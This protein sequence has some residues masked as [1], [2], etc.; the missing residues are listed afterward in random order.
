[1]VMEKIS[2]L[3]DGELDERDAQGQLK[4]FKEDPELLR[5]WHTYHLIGDAMRGE[6]PLSA[7][8]SERL[9]ARMFRA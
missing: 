1:M 2:V 8:F 4:R 5:G 7:G 6:R 9:T 3:M